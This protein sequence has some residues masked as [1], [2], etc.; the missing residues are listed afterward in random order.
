MPIQSIIEAVQKIDLETGQTDTEWALLSIYE[1]DTELFKLKM[2]DE[3]NA[4][5]YEKYYEE[6]RIIALRN[7]LHWLILNEDVKFGLLKLPSNMKSVDNSWFKLDDYFNGYDCSFTT[8]I[9]ETDKAKVADLNDEQLRK[10]LAK[11]IKNIDSNVVERESRK[12]HG[13]MEIADM[14][15]PIR[16]EK[17]FSTYYL[18]IPVKSGREI[19]NKVSEQI[20]YQVI[21][22]FTNFGNSAIVVFV[23]VKEATEGFYNYIKRAQVNLGLDIYIIDGD[24]L[25]KLLKFNNLLN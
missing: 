11:I 3:I 20:A 12:P 15:L 5:Y 4:D 19:P 16:R 17:V 2:K 6:S 7:Y 23:S 9:D 18:C 21:R 14:E 1:I 22:P 10:K 24:A 13:P 25:V 8:V